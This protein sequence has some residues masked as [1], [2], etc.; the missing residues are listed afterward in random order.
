MGDIARCSIGSFDDYYN[1]DLLYR[2][3]GINAELIID[4]AWG[5]EPCTM[6]Q[7]K[8]Y[9]PRASSMGIGQVLQSAY[10]YEWRGQDHH[11]SKCCDRTCT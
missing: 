10:S 3:F 7:V 2:M 9:R 8:E 4:H 11:N 1:E 5:Y 6:Q